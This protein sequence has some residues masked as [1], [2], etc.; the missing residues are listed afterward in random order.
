ML[1]RP[2]TQASRN[3]TS[4]EVSV[5]KSTRSLAV[6]GSAANREGRALDRKRRDDRVH[7]RSVGQAGVDVRR[8]VVHAPTDPRHDL[9]DRPPEILLALELGLRLVDL[10][11]AL[12]VDRERP[13]HH[14]LG[15]LRVADERFERPQAQDVVPDLLDDVG[16]LLD[17][18]RYLF[19][20]EK[21]A[22]TGVDQ[23]TKVA[24]RHRIVVQARAEHFDE[25]FL[26]PVAHL[27]TPIGPLL[28]REPL[29]E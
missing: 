14:D 4:C 17:R 10:A 20:S 12:D 18:E 28:P 11:P 25:S 24:V 8:R 5:P 13:V 29:C 16:L 2:R 15:D 27:D 9:V 22:Q 6:N 21:L 1:S 26:H 3:W 19:L 7:S 23:S